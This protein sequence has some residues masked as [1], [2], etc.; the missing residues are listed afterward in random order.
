M[1]DGEGTYFCGM[2]HNTEHVFIVGEFNGWNKTQLPLSSRGKS[3]IW[4]GFLPDLRVGAPYK[5]I[6]SRVAPEVNCIYM[7][8]RLITATTPETVPSRGK[9]WLDLERTAVGEVTSEDKDYPIESAFV[10]VEAAGRG[11]AGAHPTKEC[12]SFGQTPTL[13]NT[14]IFSVEQPA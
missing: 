7:R 9:G 10:S 5:S 6:N 2:A 11:S 1:Q 14:S 8:K 13:K 3:A 4:E 12:L